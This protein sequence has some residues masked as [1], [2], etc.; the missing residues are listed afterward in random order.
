MSEDNALHNSMRALAE[1]TAEAEA[2]PRVRA[3]LLK[4]VRRRRSHHVAPW[5]LAAAAALVIGV[6][7]GV[8]SRVN[9]GAVVVPDLP[10]RPIATAPVQVPEVPP[11]VPESPPAIPPRQTVNARRAVAAPIPATARLAATPWMVHQALPPA[12][13][14]QVLRLPVSA[15][16]ARQFGVPQQSGEW[17]AEIFVGDDGLA[18]AFR[19]VRMPTYK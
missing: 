3:A 2:S 15:E 9:R 1:E 12:E 10:G 6:S 5:W 17:Q 8:W 13:R 7:I 19:L 14:G 4:E 11:A 18:R 16:L